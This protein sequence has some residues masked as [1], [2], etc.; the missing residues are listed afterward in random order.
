MTGP[1]CRC[2]RSRFGQALKGTPEPVG[3]ARPG[4][5][6]VR[7]SSAPRADADP[8]ERTH[9]R[10]LGSQATAPKAI[11]DGQATVGSNRP[12]GHKT[13]PCERSEETTPYASQTLARR[14]LKGSETPAPQSLARPQQVFSKT[15]TSPQQD[16]SKSLARPQQ[17][18]SKTLASL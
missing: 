12:A 8:R 6:R 7:R 13:W 4:A 15:L 1:K 14:S 16:F 10:V 2:P 17:V 3:V 9:G 11:K 18:F 5:N